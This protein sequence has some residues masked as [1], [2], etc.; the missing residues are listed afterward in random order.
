MD[1]LLLHLQIQPEI[2]ILKKK[3][4][5]INIFSNFKMQFILFLRCSNGFFL[6]I[7]FYIIYSTKLYNFVEYMM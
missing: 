3:T 5:E 4:F 6:Q 2:A 1:K 7:L